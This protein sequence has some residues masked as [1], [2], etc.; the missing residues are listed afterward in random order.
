MVVSEFLG[1]SESAGGVAELDIGEFLSCLYDEGLVAEAVGEDDVAAFFS[2]LSSC[3]VAFLIFGDVLLEN[4]LALVEAEV[5]ACSLC[6]VHE[7]KVIGGVLIMQEYESNLDLGCVGIVVGFLVVGIVA[8][9][10]QCKDHDHCEQ[11]RCNLLHHLSVTLQNN[12]LSN[13]IL[14]FDTK[15]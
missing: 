9:C 5:L 1:V 7:V 3:V 15:I 6:C 14:S 4:V 8:A 12:L 10:A 2:K 13:S 11:K